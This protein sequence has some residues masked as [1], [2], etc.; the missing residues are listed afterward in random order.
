[1]VEII[2]FRLVSHAVYG[3]LFDFK[4]AL[5]F[6]NFCFVFACT[7]INVQFKCYH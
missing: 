7:Q 3:A 1:M 4:R 2:Y 6:L 5:F